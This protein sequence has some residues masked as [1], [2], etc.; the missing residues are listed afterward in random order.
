VLAEFMSHEKP[1]KLTTKYTATV[2]TWTQSEYRYHSTPDPV[3]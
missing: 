2:T 3:K 1:P